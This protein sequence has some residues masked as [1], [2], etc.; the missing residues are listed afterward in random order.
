[1]FSA[2]AAL[3]LSTT[4][5]ETLEARFARLVRD[6]GAPS[7]QAREE[8]SEI[9]YDDPDLDLRLIEAALRRGGLDLERRVRLEALGKRMFLRGPRGALG[10][11][12][13]AEVEGGA[14]I[15]STVE[16]FDAHRVLQAGDI[17]TAVAGVPVRSQDEMRSEILSRDPGESM[18]LTVRRAGETVQVDVS[19]RSFDDLQNASPPRGAMDEAWRVRLLRVGGP[20]SDETVLMVPGAAPPPRDVD[21]IE[22][23]TVALL[24]FAIGGESRGGVDQSGRVRVRAFGRDLSLPPVP[25]VAESLREGDAQAP[26]RILIGELQVR[27]ESVSRRVRDARSIAIDPARSPAER[28]GAADLV[29]RLADAQRII[30][31]RMKELWE[32]YDA[33]P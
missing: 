30:E 28:Q 17:I 3:F 2:L 6:L 19:L 13:G 29:A 26:V 31:E 11:Q 14:Q 33:G 21:D 4:Q 5:P 10:V 32:L 16:G 23:W 20:D 7:Y 1:M 15:Q 27:R 25:A 22:A 12:F 8:A 24:P 18:A 9:I